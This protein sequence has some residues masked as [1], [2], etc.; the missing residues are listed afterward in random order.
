M[1]APRT[2]CVLGL[3]AA[4]AGCGAPR[5]SP[6]NRERAYEFNNTGVALL[7]R[8][9]YGDAAAAFRQA[10]AVDPSLPMARVNLSLALLYDQEFAAADAEAAEAARLLPLSPQPPYILGLVARSLNRPAVARSHFER[11]TAVDHLDVGANVNLAQIALEEGRYADAVAALEPVVAAEPFNITARYVLGLALSRAGRATD[12]QVWLARAQ[13]LRD[14]G[15]GVTFGTGYLEQGRYAEAMASTGA[16]PG[17]VDLA[18][19][20]AILTAVLI[21]EAPPGGVVWPSPFGR[22]FS[23]NDLSAA[24]VR[25][26]AAGLG[27]TVTLLD[28][29][30]DGDLDLFTAS[31][32]GQHLRRNDGGTWLDIT[33]G[34][35][36]TSTPAG[37]VAVGAVAGDYDGDGWPDLF[38]LRVGGSSL[39]R[40][41]GRGGFVDAT[42]AAGLRPYPYVPGAAAFA[43]VDHDGDVDLVIAGLADVDATTR[44]PVA[45]G[46]RFPRDFAPA[47]LRLLRNNGNG[48]FADIT[49]HAGV[50]RPGHAV[51][52][53]PADFDN[54][55]DL[56]LLVVHY[57][58]APVLWSNQ[59]SGA[60]RDVTE[61]VGLARV[62]HASG[63]TSADLNHDGRPDL[64]FT[65][66]DGVVFALSDGRGGF[67]LEPGPEAARGAT[68]AQLVDYDSDGVVDLVAWTEAGLRVIRR[69]GAQW[70][71]DTGVAVSGQSAG[72]AAPSAVAVADLDA[73]GH[74]DLVEGGGA[75]L[76]LWKN[77]GDPRHRSLRVTLSGRVSN[78]LG[79]GSKVEIRAG[80]LH[81]RVDLSAATP[82]VAPADVVFGL[83]PRARAEVVRV[84]WPSGI[85]QAE[86]APAETTRGAAV[87]RVAELDRKPSSC[88]FL[89]TWNGERFEFVTD[90][91]GGG[92]M[93]NWLAPG[94]FN[95]PDPVE[96]V[97]ISGQQLRERAGRLEV[98]VTNELEEAV[99]LDDA[100]LLV[101]DHPAQVEVYPNEGL[102]VP[103]KP[104]AL[105]A[106][107]ALRPPTRVSDEHGH[108]VTARVAR[109]DRTYPDDV[110]R[111]PI[112][113]YAAPHALT[114]DLGAHDQAT[115]LVLLLT[116]WTDYAFSSDSL[117]AH[118]AGL[119]PQ[120]PRLEVRSA[121]GRWRALDVLVGIPVGRPQTIAVDLAGHLRPGDRA[122]R[123]TTN[124]QIH[125]DQIL[126]GRGVAGPA[127]APIVLDPATAV[128]GV[129]GFSAEVRPDGQD[130][131]V[132]DYARVSRTSPWKAL[133]GWY[134]RAGDVAPLVTTVDDQFAIAAS[135]DEIAITFDATRLAP[136][137]AG[138]ARTYLLRMD[139]FSKEMDINSASPYAVEPLPFHA[140][141]AYPYA[142]P[143]RYP[144]TAAHQRYRQTYNTRQIV[145]AVPLLV[146]P[147]SR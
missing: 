107:Q 75:A 103:P 30:R 26:L 14:T 40:N 133:S 47:P 138:W 118:Q 139:G 59:R 87:L 99:F 32:A 82:P 21:G 101:V 111:S 105:H 20:A 36:L 91:L 102:T 49:R 98:R 17:L 46:W 44:R 64:L 84:L 29:D 37:A 128:L 143:E 24:G 119:T 6:V 65:Q 86:I 79:I 41:D 78:R 76:R 110:V 8:L 63:V 80:S 141:S 55:R 114:F 68:A 35:G 3:V 122:L 117:A 131:P 92:E 113:G 106:V 104:F 42:R 23:A 12:G 89:F 11:V 22:H 132:Y 77:S 25:A 142:A 109:R 94:V 58:A 16:E 51:A 53:V 52:I 124:L 90:M 127:P 28:A 13:V 136:V 85:L 72:R 147:P 145:K 96:Y 60:F 54:R 137:R 2:L 38:V 39:Y 62:T 48:T 43:D 5:P 120:V 1:P 146:G 73:D 9:E 69:A 140:M 115:P 10:L 100:H 19:S 34:A 123:L 70:R 108:D 88:P 95:S 31:V 144:E 129:R 33:A 45:G 112:R 27:G 135:G 61:A 93:G 66:P 18:P 97:R 50:D 125:W 83:G 4:L 126:I 116:G 56:D 130:P 74:R 71:D 134:T 15:D 7:E 57:D 121:A 81:G 67:A